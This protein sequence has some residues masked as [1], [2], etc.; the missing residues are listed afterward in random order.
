M[1]T[2]AENQAYLASFGITK[3]VIDTVNFD[4]EYSEFIVQVMTIGMNNILVDDDGDVLTD[5]DGNV[6]YE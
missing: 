5:D 6:L 2:D 4:D 3:M 1:A